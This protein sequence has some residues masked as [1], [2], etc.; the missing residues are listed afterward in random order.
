MPMLLLESGG[1]ESSSSSTEAIARALLQLPHVADCD[2]YRL[3]AKALI[4]SPGR[5]SSTV[6]QMFRSA[7]TDRGGGAGV[8]SGAKAVVIFIPQIDVLWSRVGVELQTAIARCFRD[9]PLGSFLCGRNGG[10]ASGEW[11]ASSNRGE[12]VGDD[13]K[14]GEM[15]G[16][17]GVG[18]GRQHAGDCAMSSNNNRVCI[19]AT[20]SAPWTASTAYSID[21]DPT[22]FSLFAK[23]KITVGGD[24]RSII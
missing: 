23:S 21:L 19:L 1:G 4:S 9:F 15:K 5:A 8:L 20:S 17:D 12:N 14:C 22:I 13:G 16:K 6:R 3:D 7:I 11:R 10:G 18:Y 24:R 2:V